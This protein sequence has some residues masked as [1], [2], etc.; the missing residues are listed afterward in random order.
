M[1]GGWGHTVC[2]F[3]PV[4][5]LP[6]T[7]AW[8]VFFL[9]TVFPHF[10]VIL[11]LGSSAIPVKRWKRK[12]HVKPKWFKDYSHTTRAQVI[13]QK[14]A[15]PI[16]HSCYRSPAKPHEW[17]NELL[18]QQQSNV[19]E[20]KWLQ[21]QLSN[22]KGLKVAKKQRARDSALLAI[23]SMS[24]T[25]MWCKRLMR[26]WRQLIP[27]STIA[28]SMKVGTCFLIGISIFCQRKSMVGTWQHYTAEPFATDSDN[29]KHIIKAIK[30]DKQLCEKK[31]RSVTA[32]S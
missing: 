31:K 30:E 27:R 1:C 9:L 21:S 15:C 11:P 19:A 2:C 14:L 28:R 8:P 20:L 4:F 7:I 32:K 18:R 13:I 23:S 17:A 22:A 6:F 5:L 24:W 16:S 25:E 12:N 29:K 3:P 10:T 26:P